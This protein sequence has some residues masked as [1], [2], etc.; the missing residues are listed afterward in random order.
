MFKNVTKWELKFKTSYKIRRTFFMYFENWEKIYIFQEENT[1]KRS[2][3][4]YIPEE[5]F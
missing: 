1:Q 2:Q 5:I 4:Y 3:K